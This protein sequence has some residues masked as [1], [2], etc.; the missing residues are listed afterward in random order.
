MDAT[1]RTE[2]HSQDSSVAQ[3]GLPNQDHHGKCLTSS[4]PSVE[5]TAPPPPDLR[6]RFEAGRIDEVDEPN[7][8]SITPITQT[9]TT[10]S[11]AAQATTD[12]AVHVRVQ[13]FWNDRNIEDALRYF[14]TPPRELQVGFVVELARSVMAKEKSDAKLAAGSLLG[15]TG[16]LYTAEILRVRLAEDFH[17][18]VGEGADNLAETTHWVCEYMAHLL[19]SGDLLERKVVGLSAG[20]PDVSEHHSFSSAGTIQRR[21]A[22]THIFPFHCC[23]EFQPS[24]A[25]CDLEHLS[26]ANQANT[27]TCVLWHPLQILH[28]YD[29]D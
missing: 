27:P 22:P 15:G 4:C 2:L 1:I 28:L 24:P 18:V 6:I 16:A 19:Y 10:D 14:I 12:V 21:Y 8:E 7:V 29:V 20:L 11:A 26:A 13:T 3:T 25:W 17:H 23:A 5:P 9:S